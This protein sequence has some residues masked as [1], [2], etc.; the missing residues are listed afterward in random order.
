MFAV[1]VAAAD[2]WV[3]VESVVG[4]FEECFVVEHSGCYFG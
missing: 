3:V 2:S 4:R 1:V